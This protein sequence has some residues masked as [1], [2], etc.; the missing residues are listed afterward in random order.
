VL[1]QAER[2]DPEILTSE[3]TDALEERRRLRRDHESGN[4][5]HNERWRL[6]EDGHDRSR[7]TGRDL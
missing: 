1:D 2:C 7:D 6:A 5:F 3:I 4:R